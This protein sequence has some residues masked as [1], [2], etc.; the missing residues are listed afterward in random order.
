M[1][2][3]LFF[4]FFSVRGEVSIK[5]PTSELHD[6][7]FFSNILVVSCVLSCVPSASRKRQ[8]WRL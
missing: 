6:L 4:L 3:F 2:I 5:R 7:Y 8:Q 1:R